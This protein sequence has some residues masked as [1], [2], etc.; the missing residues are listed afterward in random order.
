MSGSA[1]QSGSR[2]P[3]GSVRLLL[4]TLR[5]VTVFSPASQVTPIQV[6][7]VPGA[8]SQLLLKFQAGPLVW[9]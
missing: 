1:D 9:W 7:S 5:A 3:T 6:H 8:P 2:A 4:C